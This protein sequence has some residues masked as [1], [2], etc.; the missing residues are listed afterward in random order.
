[1]QGQSQYRKAVSTAMLFLIC[2][3]GIWLGVRLEQRLVAGGTADAQIVKSENLFQSIQED[4]HASKTDL[5]GGPITFGTQNPLI[6]LSIPHSGADLVW[7]RYFR[8]GEIMNTLVGRYWTAASPMNPNRK[9]IGQCMLHNILDKN[10]SKP[11][12]TKNC[13]SFKAWLEIQYL[14][15]PVHRGPRKG[16]GP[17]CF[18]PVLF[19]GALDELYRALPNATIITVRQSAEE[20][21]ETLPVDVLKEWKFW[22]N[23]SHENAFPQKP[24]SQKDAVEFYN[25]YHQKI[26]EFIKD[27]DGW[28]SLEI[29]LEEETPAM[30]A[31]MLEH[32]LGI[33]A[34][35]WVDAYKGP[36]PVPMKVASAEDGT[37]TTVTKKMTRPNDLNFPIMITSLPMSGTSQAHDYFSCGLGHWASK[38]Q[39]TTPSVHNTAQHEKYNLLS[40]M[41]IGKCMEDNYNTNPNK[42]LLEGCG[43]AKVWTDVGYL[44]SQLNNGTCFYPNLQQDVLESFAS[45]CPHATLLHLYRNSTAWFQQAK[46]WHDLPERWARAQNCHA[47]FPPPQSPAQAW[48]DF[49]DAHTEQIRSFARQHSSLTYIEVPLESEEAGLILYKI[50]GYHRS[51]W[52]HAH[53]SGREQGGLR[54]RQIREMDYFFI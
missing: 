14:Q 33:L 26:H 34:K 11:L 35:C 8:C 48:H 31:D 16:E 27:H 54:S 43:H 15:P 30:L 45:S 36:V 44:H 1:M 24:Y 7:P 28:T 10:S 47:G 51:C 18:D 39:W 19:P 32:R 13:G 49:Y 52:R 46:K 40:D 41:P 3:V 37:L 5:H 4:L 23:P 20:W 22:C 25:N 6:V 42:N 17:W 12:L 29:N 21:Y 50:F 38:H 2:M 9:P 53:T